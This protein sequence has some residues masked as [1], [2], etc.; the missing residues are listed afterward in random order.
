MRATTTNNGTRNNAQ[1]KNRQV[2]QRESSGTKLIE[3]SR[4]RLLC[5]IVFFAMSFLG[6]TGKL[7]E[8]TIL[9]RNP[10]AP[11]TNTAS[12]VSDDKIVDENALPMSITRN[13]IVDRNGL[14]LATSLITQSL[15][16]NPRIITDPDQTARKLVKIF[17]D[18]HE[19]IIAKRLKSNGTFVWIK[20]NLTPREENAVNN[21]GIPGL[22]FQ[23]EQK[24]VYPY[25]NLF[26]H[27]VGF[28]G[29]D[30]TGLAGIEKY[31]DKQLRNTKDYKK[32]LQLSLDL[33]LQ[34]IV[35]EEIRKGMD[36]FN[37]IGA[38]GIILDLHNGEILAMANV[39]DF[40][41]NR[42]ADFPAVNLFNRASLGSYEMGSTFKTFTTAMALDYGT[43]NLNDGFDASRP[44]MFDHNII[45]DDHPKNRWLTIPEIYTYS[46]NIGTA[47]MVMAVG[48]EKQQIF[49]HKLGLMDSKVNIELPELGSPQ[50]PKNWSEISSITISYG[51]GMAVTPLHLMRAFAAIVNGGTYENMTLVKDGNADKPAPERVIKDATSRELRRLMRLVVQF[52]TG[53]QADVPGYRVGGK[54]GTAEKVKSTGGYS[55]HSNLSLFISTFPVDDPKYIV[56]VM[57]DDPKGNKASH[58][59]TTAGW[60]AAPFVGDIISRMAP[61]LGLRPEFD[62]PEDPVNK[63][64]LNNAIQRLSIKD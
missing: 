41:P 58:G 63:Y 62:V 45:K 18:L 32:P 11:E 48:K 26:S 61:L 59:F 49:L 16:A 52:G 27:V 1:P 54:T 9:H 46:S 12:P 33:R 2:I 25:K 47:R 60:V 3:Q 39:P 56:L 5:I 21:L 40:D 44:F 57:M 4:T 30:G 31:F 64:W 20:R 8:I 17:P 7:M 36:E 23:P 24:R 34:N 28:V 51:H 35:A 15:F 6:I 50:Y 38:T 22:Y 19:H 53:K 10:E 37:A 55:H 42:P 14:V 29:L 43:V 13:D